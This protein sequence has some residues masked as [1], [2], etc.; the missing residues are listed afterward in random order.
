MLSYWKVLHSWSYGTEHELYIYIN[1]INTATY[2]LFL[3]NLHGKKKQIINNNK[4]KP[5]AL[6]QFILICHGNNYYW[7][8]FLLFSLFRISFHFFGRFSVLVA[9]VVVVCFTIVLL[10]WVVFLCFLM[11]HTH[12]HTPSEKYKTKNKLN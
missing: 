1:N 3:I 9:I 6:I 10:A 4:N 5:V 11:T 12:T 7:F 2:I 8:I